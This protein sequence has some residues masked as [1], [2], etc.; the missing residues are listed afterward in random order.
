MICNFHDGRYLVLYTLTRLQAGKNLALN[1]LDPQFPF[2]IRR[3]LKVPRLTGQRHDDKL[4]GVFLLW[5]T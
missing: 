5:K 1:R 2:L 3:C 4:K